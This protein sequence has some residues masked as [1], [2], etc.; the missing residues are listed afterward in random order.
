MHVERR[1]SSK[2]A[3]DYDYLTQLGRQQAAAMAARL[4]R[5]VS[6]S[7][8][9]SAAEQRTK[10]T[11]AAIANAC[12]LPTPL[13][14]DANLTSSIKGETDE[15]RAERGIAAVQRFLAKTKGDVAV[16]SHGHIIN[17]MMASIN[18]VPLTAEVLNLESA[19]VSHSKQ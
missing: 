16:V 12:R 6:L 15:A 10:D 4:C 13:P 1:G 8:A 2:S 7:A 18:G 3:A 19:C 9:E 11:A 5:S 17:L 14:F